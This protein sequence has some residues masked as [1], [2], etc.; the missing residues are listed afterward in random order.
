MQRRGP[1]LLSASPWTAALASACPAC[2]CSSPSLGG[3]QPPLQSHGRRGSE[4]G[5]TKPYSY[6]KHHQPGKLEEG[7]GRHRRRSQKHQAPAALSQLRRVGF[8]TCN[9]SLRN[10]SFPV[11]PILRHCVCAG[12]LREGLVTTETHLK[13]DFSTKWDP[14]CHE[15]ADPH[16]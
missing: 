13:G 5:L 15:L 4:Q 11:C 9:P 6:L 14:T 8:A 12:S 2:W 16:G 3:L 10:D 1:M 7:H